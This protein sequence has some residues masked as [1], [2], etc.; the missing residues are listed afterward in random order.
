MRLYRVKQLTI[1]WDGAQP[2]PTLT[3]NPQIQEWQNIMKSVKIKVTRRN[4]KTIVKSDEGPEFMFGGNILSETVLASLVFQTLYINFEKL[5]YVSDTF[6]ISLSM[7]Y[8]VH[9]DNSE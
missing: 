5:S 9:Q 1:T 4:G 7:D 8:I 3:T 2:H 6:E